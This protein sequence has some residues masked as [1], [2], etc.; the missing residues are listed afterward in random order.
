M[1]EQRH[2]CTRTSIL[3]YT[4]IR[5]YTHTSVHTHPCTPMHRPPTSSRR[6][7]LKS[8]RLLRRRPLLRSVTTTAPHLYHTPIST[9]GR[10][11]ARRARI[12]LCRLRGDFAFF[13]VPFLSAFSL[14]ALC[15][16]SR[17]AKRP[18]ACRTLLRAICDIFLTPLRRRFHAR[19][20]R[21]GFGAFARR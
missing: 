17:R 11:A 8:R 15:T 21:V 10:E 4:H 1:R 20:S 7:E 9:P 16:A 6:R 18:H 19:F 13:R 2:K 5:T 14:L 3:T 12:V